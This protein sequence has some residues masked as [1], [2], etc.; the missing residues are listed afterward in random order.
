MNDVE[1]DL[2]ELFD[3]KAGSLGTV[4]PKLPE[5]VRTRGRR[6]QLG[7]A[8]V[9]GL[10]VLAVVVGAVGALQAIDT[11]RDREP[12]PV[13]D[14]WTGYEVYERTA[15]ISSVTITSPS[16]LY[17]VRLV[18]PECAADFDCGQ[19]PAGF[20][21][22]Q[23]TNFDPGLAAEVCGSDLPPD[24]VGLVVSLVFSEGAQRDPAWP[25]PIDERAP[26]ED[27]PCGPGRYFRFQH[28]GVGYM[29]WVGAGDAAPDG[30]VRTVFRSLAGLEIDDETGLSGD[31]VHAAYVIAGGTNAAGPWR[32]ETRPSLE[33]GSVANAEVILVGPDG[34]PAIEGFR[35]PGIAVEQ[36]GGDPTFGAVTKDA[37]VVE[38]RPDD[39]SPSVAANVVPLP[40]SMPFDFD[41][42][43]GSY[44]ADVP[45]RAVAL[46]EDGAKL[47]GSAS[48]RDVLVNEDGL[49]VVARFDA[50]G[51][52]WEY[53][54]SRG[55]GCSDSFE[56]LEGGVGG[57]G[58]CG[59]G[60]SFG[61]DGPP[62]AFFHGPLNNGAVTARVVTG[63]GR[64]YPAIAVGSTPDGRMY[65]IVAVEGSG[66]GTLETLD[67]QGDVVRRSPRQSW[68]DYGQVISP[69]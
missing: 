2:R 42:F 61:S 21:L 1:R 69:A 31:H 37:A 47:E 28:G 56:N 63:D 65:Y 59:E 9:S 12:T 39:G 52:T 44:D 57:G 64:V 48:A 13:D 53:S 38:L 36:A 30:D 33:G 24:G 27:G 60:G 14:P 18:D 23:L 5:P 26:T 20:R 51:S 34:G 43:F 29:A 67:A 22:L 8:L 54:I 4:A 40:P 25:I 19:A 15:T 32:L 10:T 11:G 62:H 58:S 50:F 49:Y 3:R 16:D 7:T 66:P 35:V 17:L 45:A 55:A 6:R 41:L 46:D 68:E